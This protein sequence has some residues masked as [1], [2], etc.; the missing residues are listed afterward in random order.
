MSQHYESVGGRA[1]VVN[2]KMTSYLRAVEAS[3]VAGALLRP[4]VFLANTSTQYQV[5]GI[6]S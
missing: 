3:V 4:N 5:N 1:N 2:S 6:N